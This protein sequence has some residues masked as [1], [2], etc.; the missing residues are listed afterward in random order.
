MPE[1]TIRCRD[2]STMTIKSDELTEANLALAE[3]LLEMAAE[4]GSPT[5]ELEERDFD[6]VLRRLARKGYTPSGPVN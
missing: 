4:R 1:R 2:G 5:L 6:E 3:V